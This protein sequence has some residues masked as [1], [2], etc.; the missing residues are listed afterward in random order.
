MAQA[1]RG[2]KLNET[3]VTIGGKK[4]FEVV[5]A[6]GDYSRDDIVRKAK[7]L[8][9]SYQ[10]S[11]SKWNYTVAM[12]YPDGWYA[13]YWQSTAR[14][15]RLYQ[16]RDSPGVDR[17]DPD[18]YTQFVVYLTKGK[19]TA[20]GA[21]RDNDCLWYCLERVAPEAVKV[22]P[23]R[24]PEALKRYLGLGRC[25]KV[26]IKHID[27]V[28]EGLATCYYPYAINVTGNHIRTSSI[29]DQRHQINLKLY[30]GH[31]T[32]D[33]ERHP[34]IPKYDKVDKTVIMYNV[35]TEMGYF[36]DTKETRKLTK[37]EI[38]RYR[39]YPDFHTYIA[40]P[41]DEW[42]DRKDIGYE[43]K[44]DQGFPL[45]KIFR[46]FQRDAITLF[47]A[48]GINV[49][50]TGSVARTALH[51][52]QETLGASFGVE[53]IRQDEAEWL[54]KASTGAI[55]TSKGAYKGE[56]HLYDIVSMYPGFMNSN[57]EYFPIRRGV[58]KTITESDLK[59]NRKTGEPIYEYG[60]YR[61]QITG[62]HGALRT[63][64][65][66]P[67]NHYCFLDLYVARRHGY[68]IKLIE[69]GQ[70]N[71]L[72]YEKKEH[73]L[74]GRNLFGKFIDRMY[75]L[76]QQKMPFAKAIMNAL[77][78]ALSES[79]SYKRQC[80]PGKKVD[81]PEDVTMKKTRPLGDDQK[82]GIFASYVKHDQEFKTSYARIKPFIMSLGRNHI[83]S[84][85]WRYLDKIVRICTDGFI[86]TEKLEIKTGLEMGDLKYEGRC[87]EAFEMR[88]TRVATKKY[89]W[90]P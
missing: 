50:L 25:D 7:S 69:D 31:Y 40:I 20:G 11:D 62:C 86:A 59:R 30:N 68:T 74:T 70:P 90:D 43:K 16:Y 6:R 21:G 15:P 76:K 38:R 75:V 45:D 23:F 19:V 34:T 3:G 60:I 32:I 55:I 53:A 51:V 72:H 82:D 73:M 12:R 48:S 36:S 8:A 79:K 17:D 44:G 14:P 88:N 4:M 52:W 71:F 29:A 41:H 10:R 64:R 87:R 61:C 56:A 26:D 39:W 13:G 84:Y 57:N 65:F 67:T 58:F 47:K 5:F 49:G 24:T 81:I 83:Y 46:K 63:F 37:D 2:Y 66:N 42:Y 35:K 77:W 27:K 28:E 80:M 78:G 9:E 89:H 18:R 33:H 22:S 54:Q 1:G 85:T